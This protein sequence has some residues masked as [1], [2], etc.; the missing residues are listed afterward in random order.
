MKDQKLLIPKQDFYPLYR[1]GLLTLSSSVITD[2]TRLTGV[3]GDGAS[4][5]D[6]SVGVWPAA[7]NYVTN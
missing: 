4:Y 2:I 6:S 7:T 1:T 3:E 5:P